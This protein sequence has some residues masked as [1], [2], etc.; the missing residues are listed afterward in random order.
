[1]Y[2]IMRRVILASV[3]FIQDNTVFEGNFREQEWLA[4]NGDLYT[5]VPSLRREVVHYRE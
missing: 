5:R 4:T 2:R 3:V 1:M